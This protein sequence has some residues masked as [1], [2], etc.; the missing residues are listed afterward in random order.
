[1]AAVWKRTGDPLGDFIRLILLLEEALE[2]LGAPPEA[3]LGAK[4]HSGAALAFFQSYPDG[5]EVRA[6][7][8]RLVEVRNAVLHERAEVPPWAF[9]EGEALLRRMLL[10]L[11]RQGFYERGE[12]AERVAFLQAPPPPEPAPI[13]EAIPPEEA[14]VPEPL[15]ERPKRPWWALRLPLPI[16]ARALPR[17]LLP[18]P[19]RR[20][21]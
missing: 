4:L 8:W 19:K 13:L 10:A 7:L 15:R 17:R 16:P 2:R 5:E 6:R 14:R 9:E 18:V 11:E 3:T 12:L 20:L 1:M 21:R